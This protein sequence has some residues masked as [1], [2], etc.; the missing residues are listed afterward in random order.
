[1]PFLDRLPFFDV[2]R[3]HTHRVRDLDLVPFAPNKAIGGE[4][5]RDVLSNDFGDLDDGELFGLLGKPPRAKANGGG[6]PH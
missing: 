2:D 4:G 6:Q 5:C 1:M 3:L